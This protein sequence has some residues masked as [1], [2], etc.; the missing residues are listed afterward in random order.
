MFSQLELVECQVLVW[1]LPDEVQRAAPATQPLPNRTEQRE[2]C[3]DFSSKA[4][5][6]LQPINSGF[7][8]YF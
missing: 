2:H 3:R 7:P 8:E 1:L 6:F 5:V 4:P